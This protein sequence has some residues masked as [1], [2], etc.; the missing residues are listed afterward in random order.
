M[1]KSCLLVAVVLISLLATTASGCTSSSRE[2]SENVQSATEQVSEIEAPSSIPVSI[3]L[4]MDLGRMIVHFDDMKLVDKVSSR[5][6]AKDCVFVLVYYGVT[7]S[8]SEPDR[9]PGFN[10][11]IKTSSGA[12]YSQDDDIETILPIDTRWCP[13]GTKIDFFSALQPG[14]E[15]RYVAA[16]QL[17]AKQLLDGAVLFIPASPGATDFPI[18]NENGAL[19]VRETGS[20]PLP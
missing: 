19:R 15:Q 17:P 16:L 7:N 8:G 4:Q 6:P 2:P 1:D 12:T 14:V 3:D 10:I 13:P 20:S 5:V 18:E 9:F 11:G